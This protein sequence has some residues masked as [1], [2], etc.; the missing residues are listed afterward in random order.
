MNIDNTEYLQQYLGFTSGKSAI[1][2][3]TQI[4][5]N[6]VLISNSEVVKRNER[7]HVEIDIL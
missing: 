1:E 7:V 5:R 6:D 4:I 2:S 3:N